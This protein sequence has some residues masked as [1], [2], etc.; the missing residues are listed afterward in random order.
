MGTL[1]SYTHPEFEHLAIFWHKDF[2]LSSAVTRVGVGTFVLDHV[3]QSR[4]IHT[5]S[6]V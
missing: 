1:E 3:S 2:R 4:N 6:Y 5:H